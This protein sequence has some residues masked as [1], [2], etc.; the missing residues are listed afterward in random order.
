MLKEKAKIIN[1]LKLNGW[2]LDRDTWSSDKEKDEFWTY[3]KEGE[4]SVDISDEEMV[5][6]DGSGDFL[7]R[8]LDYYTLIGVLNVHACY[9]SISQS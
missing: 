7:N 8:P 5:F 2:K 3:N 6:L 9:I 1:L 4:I